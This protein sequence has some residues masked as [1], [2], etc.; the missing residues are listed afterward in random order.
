VI[1]RE[2]Q[3]ARTGLKTGACV[4]ANGSRNDKGVVAATRIT[5]SSPVDGQ[6]TGGFRRGARPNAGR[7]PARTGTTPRRPPGGNLGFAVGKVAAVDGDTLTVS[8]SFGTTR[9]TTKV[10]VSATTRLQRTIRARASAISAGMCA[11]V[12][13]AS[14]DKGITVKAQRV[15]LTR[16]VNGSCTAGFRRPG[17][18]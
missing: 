8:G 17:T 14:S 2:I 15:S 18:G 13:G 11:F 6:C 10:T 12:N 1:T 4:V 5:L 3:A 9:V 7:P 16:K